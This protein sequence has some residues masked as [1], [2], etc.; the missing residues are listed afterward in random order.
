M[1]KFRYNQF[2]NQRE[3]FYLKELKVGDLIFMNTDGRTSYADP[4]KIKV[5]IRFVLAKTVDKIGFL[6]LDTQNIEWSI[7]DGIYP[8]KKPNSFYGVTKIVRCES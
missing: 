8:F 6:R 2:A 3:F 1:S 4:V 5:I 7:P